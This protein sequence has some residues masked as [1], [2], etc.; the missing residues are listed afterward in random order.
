[1]LVPVQVI[2]AY[3]LALMELLDARDE[4]AAADVDLVRE[5]VGNYG[6]GAESG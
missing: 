1:M 3:V 5:A 6:A 2:S 4:D